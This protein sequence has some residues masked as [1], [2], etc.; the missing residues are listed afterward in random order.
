MSCHGGMTFSKTVTWIGLRP[1]MQRGRSGQEIALFRTRIVPADGGGDT[2]RACADKCLWMRVAISVKW[3]VVLGSVVAQTLS[4]TARPECMDGNPASSH[5]SDI[6]QFCRT[7]QWI[8]C[9][10][11]YDM[12]YT[13]HTEFYRPTVGLSSQIWRTIAFRCWRCM[14]FISFPAQ[15]RGAALTIDCSCLDSVVGH[16]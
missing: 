8:V 6:M 2:G 4:A 12:S 11:S 3:G 14:H 5:S 15:S 9:D 1:Y 13:R 16:Q 10:N 7:V